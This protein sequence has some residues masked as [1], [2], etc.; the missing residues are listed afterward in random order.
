MTEPTD[1]HDPRRRRVLQGLGGL[2]LLAAVPSP[3][4]AGLLSAEGRSERELAFECRKTGES[5][6]VVYWSRGEYLQDAMSEIDHLFRDLRAD[7][8]HPIDPAL[9]DFLH[10]LHGRLESRTPFELLS[11]YRSPATNEMLRRRGPGV[12]KRSQHVLGKAVDI[13]LGDRGV[14]RIRRAAISLGRAKLKQTI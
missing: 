10:A 6:K 13:R 12:A 8:V 2:A 5:C 1:S 11:G 4:R 14:G 9:L 7:A 3:V